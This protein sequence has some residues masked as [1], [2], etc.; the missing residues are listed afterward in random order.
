MSI[1]GL[2]C[3]AGN[4]VKYSGEKCG[5]VIWPEAASESC[6]NIIKKANAVC[7]T[8]QRR[9][10]YITRGITYARFM[11]LN[12]NHHSDALNTVP[13]TWLDFAKL[14]S[15]CMIDTNTSRNGQTPSLFSSKMLFLISNLAWQDATSLF[16]VISLAYA[17]RWQSNLFAKMSTLSYKADSFWWISSFRQ[18]VKI[19]HAM[20]VFF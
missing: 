19:A 12:Y 8:G 6:L 7:L 3:S 13:V 11:G 1:V 16:W 14:Y 4:V 17:T 5:L 20:C 10:K 2:I 9:H 15:G 18:F